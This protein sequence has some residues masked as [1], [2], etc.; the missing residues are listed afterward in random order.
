MWTDYMHSNIS[1]FDFIS[2]MNAA[3]PQRPTQKGQGYKP[4]QRFKWL[5]ETHADENGKMPSGRETLDLWN[6]IKSFN[7]ERSLTGNWQ[8]L[9]PILD[10]V[11]TRANMDGVGRMTFI[12][13]HPTNDQIMFVGTPAGGVWKTVNGGQLWTT[14]S[15]QLPTLGVSSIAFDPANPNIVY[16]GTGDR[17]AGDSPGMGVLRSDD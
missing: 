11:T 10:G 17:D 14:T 4:L 16:A 2:E 5:M 13:F 3:W 9:G 12:A 8:P 1:V 15:D 6:A 7:G